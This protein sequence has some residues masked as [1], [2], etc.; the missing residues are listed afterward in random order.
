MS[1]ET[2]LETILDKV[3]KPARYIGGELNS[4]VKSGEEVRTRFAL[5]FPDLYEIGMSH[6]GMKILYALKNARDDI[7]CERVFAPA[8]DMEALMR[9]DSLPLY[10]LESL[11][12]VREFDII[13]FSLQ[14][15]LCYTTLLNM[16]D[17][18]GL[19]L[20][21]ADRTGL[22]PIVMAGGP[23]VCNPE[24]LAAFVDLFA[25]GEGEE[26]NLE[27]IDL[28]RQAKEA[29]WDKARFLREAAHIPG[30]YVPSLYD[31]TYHDD[32]TV[33]AI[34]PR[35]GA[36]ARVVKRIVKQLD[37]AYFP[38]SVV[39]P[40]IEIVHDRS[41]LEVQRGCIRG[42][43]FC[44]AGFLYRP[45]R[46]KKPA[47]LAR[48]AR[49]LSESSGYDEISL[50]SL[51]TSDYTGLEALLE[52]L[53]PW[54][55]E[56]QINLSLPSLRIDSCSERLLAQI[57][58]VRRSG[59]TFAPEAGTQRLRDAINK[60]LT[61]EE[62]LAT[63]RAAFAGGYAAVKL[64]FMM[65]LPTETLEDIEGIAIL[66]QKVIDAFYH[67]P[68]RPKGKGVQVTLSVACFVPKPFTPFAFE[69]QDTP[70]RLREKQKHLLASI[71]NRK[72]S[73][74]YHDSTTSVLEGVLARGDRRLCDVIEEVWRKGSTLDSWNEHFDAAR[75]EAAF[76]EHGVD[77]AFYTHRRRAYDEFM[78]WSHL[79]YGVSDAYLIRENKRAHQSI[80]TPH[81]RQ[82]CGGC[83]AAKLVTGE[84]VS[85][86]CGK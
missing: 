59:L 80:A 23:C 62:I 43:R 83:G 65:G 50:T 49:N 25:L 40:F 66:A 5:C 44:Q 35:D 46:D 29:G 38:A 4:V 14:Y 78:P 72:I 41:M 27:I 70:E 36:P 64:Y 68:D 61:E 55:K 39:V 12:P 48:D 18:A 30:V 10:G 2:K 75:W 51:S 57:A 17:L 3:Q 60:N 81:C 42:C 52:T 82:G 56:R 28:H 16:L 84:G 11:E 34:T 45:L 21:S 79:D 71:R 58:Q 73:V 7:W 69:P 8:A 6:L 13:G 20:R 85:V 15:E 1:L 63:C 54:A 53:L 32:G 31:V 47:T 77:P 19:P 9:R 86:P 26:V 67:M 22:S 33:A 74:K 37:D 24:P 76:V